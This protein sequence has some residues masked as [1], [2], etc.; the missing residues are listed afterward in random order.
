MI[1]KRINLALQGGGAHGAFTWGVLDRILEDERLEI[2]AITGTSAGALNGAALKSGLIEDGA[3][4][5]KAK[6]DWLWAEI[7]GSDQSH[8]HSWMHGVTPGSVSHAVESSPF[9]QAIDI[10][11]RMASPYSL[12]LLYS[13]PLRPIVEQMNFNEICAT[14]GPD[15]FICA[16]NVRS[17]K[18]RI[19]DRHDTDTDAILA[20]GCL[21]TIFQAVEIFDPKTDRV[22][23]YWDGGYMGNPALFPLFEPEFPADVVIVNINPLY[24]EAL[25]RKATEIQNRINEISFNGSLFRELRA[26]QFV[27]D[28]IASGKVT[29]GTMKDVLVH[30][31]SDDALMNKLSVATKTVPTPFVLHELKQAGR[32]AAHGFLDTHFDDLGDRSSVDLRA[33]FD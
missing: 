32:D 10:F 30:M 27:R 26:V 28:L 5:A 20:S 4:G 29:R 8:L 14:E 18:I 31:I 17:G 6:L 21:P 22:E 19:F 24:R 16:T 25:P 1:P 12:G 11:S 33:M 9:Y 7:G 13:H 15:L 2:A 3:D 23:A